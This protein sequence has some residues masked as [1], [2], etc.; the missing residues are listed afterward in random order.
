MRPG[1]QLWV[2]Q[3][4][5]QVH[6]APRCR[7]VSSQV[8]QLAKKFH[9]CYC[10]L[11]SDET[12]WLWMLQCFQS[13]ASWSA[14]VQCRSPPGGRQDRCTHQPD[15]TTC[16]YKVQAHVIRH[17]KCYHYKYK[18]KYSLHQVASQVVHCIQGICWGPETEFVL[19]L[20]TRVY[21]WRR[22]I[23]AGCVG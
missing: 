5:V 1:L 21:F 13:P 6:L 17:D 16:F 4:Q 23:W 8:H 11:P 2:T 20:C 7:W 22:F 3:V 10:H 14:L 18:Y 12:K 15:A 19:H 9:M